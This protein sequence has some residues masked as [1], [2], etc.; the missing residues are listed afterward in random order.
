[1]LGFLS[2]QS[3]S[4]VYCTTK[5]TEIHPHKSNGIVYFKFMDGTAIQGTESDSGLERNMSVALSAM[6]ADRPVKIALND[7]EECGSN[8]YEKWSYIVALSNLQ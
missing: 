3:Y 8:R 7:G 5:V 4:Y 1:M 2:G 6:M